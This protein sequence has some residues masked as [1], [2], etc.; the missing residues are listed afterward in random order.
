MQPSFVLNFLDD[1]RDR[2]GRVEGET[3]EKK[4]GRAPRR[5]TDE[6]APPAGTRNTQPHGTPAY[7]RQTTVI[8]TQ[9]PYLHKHQP[10][11]LIDLRRCSKCSAPIFS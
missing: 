3:V 7:R 11:T 6:D 4:R 1:E 2:C 5:H 9:T 8:R 10:D